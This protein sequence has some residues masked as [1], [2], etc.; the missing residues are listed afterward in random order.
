MSANGK[1]GELRFNTIPL[2]AC[3]RCRRSGE[4]CLG[5]PVAIAR[6][7]QETIVRSVCRRCRLVWDCSWNVTALADYFPNYEAFSGTFIRAAEGLESHPRE[8]IDFPAGPRSAFV[9]GKE[10]QRAQL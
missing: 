9:Q 7:A 10:R 1:H 5:S 4:R 3:P 2:D 8:G 6:R